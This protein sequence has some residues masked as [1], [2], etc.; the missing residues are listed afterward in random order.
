MIALGQQPSLQPLEYR[1]DDGS[2]SGDELISVTVAR[3]FGL[4]AVELGDE[5]QCLLRG[6]SFL[7]ALGASLLG[8]TE[9]ASRVCPAADV[10][11]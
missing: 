8:V 9:A 3:A 6:S 7:G 11:L 2:A 5:R 1:L 4:G 10:S